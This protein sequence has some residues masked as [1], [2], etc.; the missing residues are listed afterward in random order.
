MDE[1]ERIKQAALKDLENLRDLATLEASRVKHLGRNS[2][3]SALLRSVKEK[4]ADERRQIGEFANRMRTELEER[5]IQVRDQVMETI[6]GARQ[7]I[8]V[9]APAAKLRRGHIHPLTQ[10]QSQINDIFASMG[11]RVLEGPEVETDFTNFEALN[12]PA[13][14]PAREMQDTFW[15]KGMQY[16]MRTHTSTMQVRFMQT[17]QPPFRIIVPGRVYRNEATDITHEFQFHQIEGLMVSRKG[18]QAPSLANLKGV[19][20]H[21]FQRFFDDPGIQVRFNASYFPFVEPGVEVFVQGTSGK[22][23]GKWLEVAGAGMVHQNV[24]EKAGYVKGEMQGFAF[25][26]AL[27][28]MAML[29]YKIDDIRLFNGGDVRFLQQF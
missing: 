3:L 23:A 13:D 7:R 19:M 2:E 29:K 1:L 4:T 5:F 9:T 24:F 15:L 22:L 27:E 14:H 12:F 16:L 17:H 8:D 20:E 6:E 11:F 28:R 18:P 21:F 10:V 26:M 25:G